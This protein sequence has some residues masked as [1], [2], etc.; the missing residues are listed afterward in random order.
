MKRTDNRG[1]IGFA[2]TA[3]MTMAGC[4]GGSYVYQRSAMS[5][6]AAVT[7][8][9]AFIAAT[10]TPAMPAFG[11]ADPVNWKGRPPQAYP[12]HGIDVSRYQGNI[13]WPTTRANGVSFAFIKATEGIDYADTA[14]SDN[15]YGAMLAGVPRGAYHFY[16][17]C[18][19][20]EEQARWFIAN[21][22][23]ERGS[24]PPVLDLEW[25]ADSRTCPYRPETETV[26]SEVQTFLSI[27]GRHYN[28]QPIVYT[29]PDFWE[30]NELWRLEGAHP[31]LRSVAAHPSERYP[32]EQWTFWQ[33]SGTGLVPGIAGQVDLNTFAGSRQDWSVWVA[34]QAL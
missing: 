30:T 33:Y 25:N 6:S 20:A 11:D 15:W 29:T 34:Y 7:A 23:K 22:P 21:V 14:F 17:F 27:V 10:A 5:T 32:G 8:A 2:L 26:L 4:G 1:A 19:S 3:L 24:L 13:D 12:V 18:R 31:W 28:Q 9:P 16:Y